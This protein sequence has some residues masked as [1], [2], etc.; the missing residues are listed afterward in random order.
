MSPLQILN[1]E[2]TMLLQSPRFGYSSSIVPVTRTR[3]NVVS[4]EGR[5]PQPTFGRGPSYKEE[6]QRERWEALDRSQREEFLQE[7]QH[8]QQVTLIRE[9][10]EQIIGAFTLA[11]LLAQSTPRQRPR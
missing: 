11:F 3:Q 6:K 2:S 9:F 4:A 1:M 8:R 5:Q 7:A 10:Q